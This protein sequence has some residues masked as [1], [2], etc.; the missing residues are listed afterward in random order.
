MVIHMIDAPY[1]NKRPPLPQKVVKAKREKRKDEKL[2]KEER[3]KR[4]EAKEKSKIPP[5]FEGIFGVKLLVHTTF[6]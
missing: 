5:T 2:L 4:I 6:N 3:A 1:A